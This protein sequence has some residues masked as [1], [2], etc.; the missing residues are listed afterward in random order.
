MDF[1]FL[2]SPEKQNKAGM[3]SVER[4]FCQKEEPFGY[5]DYY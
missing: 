5:Y 1:D 4:R 2:D 3:K